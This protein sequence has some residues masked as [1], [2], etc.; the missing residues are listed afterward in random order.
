MIMGTS[1]SSIRKQL[2]SLAS[3]RTAAVMQK[4]FKT[5]PGEYGEGDVFLGIKVPPQREVAKASAD[6]PVEQVPE[7]LKSE[8]HEH[9][10]VALMIWVL[11]FI[12]GDVA[13]RQR[14]YELY[15]GHT[16]W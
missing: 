16:K 3:A 2:Q 7:L 6:L 10:S 14:I 8:V 5:G 1:V 4:F 13:T 12:R 9:R 11:Q 15:L